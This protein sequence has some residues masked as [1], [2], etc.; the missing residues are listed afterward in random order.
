M[1]KA[2]QFIKKIVFMDKALQFI[3]NYQI[4]YNI[5]CNPYSITQMM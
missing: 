1:V 2:Q 5:P 4:L 3:N